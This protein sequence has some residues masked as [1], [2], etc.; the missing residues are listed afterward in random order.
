[1]LELSTWLSLFLSLRHL[2]R[3]PRL[4]R[5]T[6]SPTAKSVGY[7]MAWMRAGWRTADLRRL[8]VSGSSNSS[9]PSSNQTIGTYAS[10]AFSSFVTPCV[11]ENRDHLKLKAEDYSLLTL[12]RCWFASWWQLLGPPQ[13]EAEC[14]FGTH[15]CL[16]PAWDPLQPTILGTSQL[17]KFDLDLN[18]SWPGAD[19]CLRCRNVAR[20]ATWELH[21]DKR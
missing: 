2:M 11:L 12:G 8:I 17:V 19:A 1:M 14:Q 3:Q 18:L 6:R 7:R 4:K 15:A 13:S 5:S 20:R 21:L 9:M 10:V 16:G